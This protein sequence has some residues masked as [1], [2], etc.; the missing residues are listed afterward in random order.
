[1]R[2]EIRIAILLA[3]LMPGCSRDIAAKISLGA[4]EVEKQTTLDATSGTTYRAWASYNLHRLSDDEAAPNYCYELQLDVLDGDKVVAEER[5]WP[6]PTNECQ[7]KSGR[8]AADCL[9]DCSWRA[10]GNAKLT[11][12]AKLAKT[13]KKCEAGGPMSPS[14]SCGPA[15]HRCLHALEDPRAQLKKYDV[16]IEKVAAK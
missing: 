4:A 7:K 1:M 8:R 14:A 3:C 15:M 12:R 10:K 2:S 11:V 9:S 6:F 5:C 13:E 16:R